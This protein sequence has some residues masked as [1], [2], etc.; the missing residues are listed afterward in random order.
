MKRV[1]IAGPMTGFPDFNYP[2]FNAQ[3]A[4]LRSLGFH[5]ENPAENPKPPSG[6]WS[7]YMRLSIAQVVTCDMVVV[8]DGWAESRGA[9]IEVELALDL[10]MSV[11]RADSHEAITRH[12][13]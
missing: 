1:Y 6:A 4:T 9:R 10:G 11:I 12:A 13:A 7:D 3:A 8:L 5:V 2:A